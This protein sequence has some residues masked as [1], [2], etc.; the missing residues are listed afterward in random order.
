[1]QGKLKWK[2]EQ[3]RHLEDVLRKV[4]GEFKESEKQWGSDISTLVDQIAALETSLDSKTRV[5]EEF[6]SRLEMCSQALAHE[7]GRRRNLEAEMA[8]LGRKYG[9]VVSEYEEARMLV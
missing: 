8:D 4:R 5:A 7:E 6:R 2:A 1:M 9:D 3:F